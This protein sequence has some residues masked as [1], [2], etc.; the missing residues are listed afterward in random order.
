[1]LEEWLHKHSER[2]GSD[3]GKIIGLNQRDR[4]ARS[5]GYE[6]TDQKTTHIT[7]FSGS[8]IVANQI[9]EHY[10]AA[11]DLLAWYESPEYQSIAH[12]RRAA[13]EANI[14]LVQGRE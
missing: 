12:H 13:S 9:A 3:H 7:S 4:P 11:K 14:V 6:M 8:V 1:M 5:I 2:G 10:L